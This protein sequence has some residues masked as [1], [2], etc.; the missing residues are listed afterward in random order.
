MKVSAFI[1]NKAA[2][3]NTTD[4]ATIYFR[5]RD[6]RTKTDIKAASELTINP[7]HWSPERQG[8]KGRV[9]MV[10]DEERLA[11]NRSILELTALISR[12]FY[13]GAS[14]TW[15]Q[16]LIF[17]YH[18][19]NAYK[20]EKGKIIDMSFRSW[21]NKYLKVKNFSKH[22]ACNVKGMADKVER[23]ERFK[24]IVKKD[25]DY[26][27][28]IGTI[29]HKDLEEF[30]NYLYHENGYYKR[31]PNLFK[32]ITPASRRRLQHKRGVNTMNNIFVTIR[33]VVRYAIKNGAPNKNPFDDFEM[34]QTLYGTPYYLT[35]EEREKI[36]NL[37]LSDNPLLSAYRDM[38]IFQ[39]HV[40]CRYGD[41][42]SFTTDNIIDGV[43]EYVPNKTLRKVAS[44][45]RV[46]LS[47]K[48][49]E[50]LARQ[51]LKE[52]DKLF[53]LHFNF[54]YNDA[55]RE[56]MTRAG[57]TRMVTIIN[58]STR[59]EE[60]K[61]INELASSHLARRTFIGNLYKQVKD[62][63]LIA[64]MSGHVQGS[65]AFIRYRTIDDDIKK[66]LIELIQ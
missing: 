15:L 61:H 39:C 52:G 37:D 49:K 40:G 36:Y 54:K 44:S 19:P 7:N 59:M 57:I 12:E 28:T 63:N 60:K 23:F 18:H 31:Y 51:D 10:S 13:I 35:L 26:S 4:R 30:K 47:P 56:I 29:D 45:V 58:S 3:N 41:L 1:R 20:L 11:L 48:A 2:K 34:P 21:V 8:Y 32:N 66:E 27:F 38:F 55:I 42:I 33:A 6:V 64:S 24:R 17:T 25:K 14:N 9:V 46:P 43:L 62:P 22:Q 50:I 65:K 53:T 16:K 5:V